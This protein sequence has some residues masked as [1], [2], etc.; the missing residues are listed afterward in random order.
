MNYRRL[1][2]NRQPHHRFC[3]HI[4]SITSHTICLS[5]EATTRV[6]KTSESTLRR[7][8]GYSWAPIVLI[9][10]QI[11]NVQLWLHS[12]FNLENLLPAKVFASSIGQCWSPQPSLLENQT[13]FRC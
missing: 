2:N 3:L 10:I 13:M 12:F 9:M 8:S 1:R 5:P 7:C 6:V 4:R 11:S